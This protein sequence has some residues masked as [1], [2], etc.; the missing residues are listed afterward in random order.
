MRDSCQHQLTC[1]SST[2]APTLKDIERTLDAVENRYKSALSSSHPSQIHIPLVQ[3]ISRQSA[4]TH[5]TR[6]TTP[7]V[8]APSRPEQRAPSPTPEPP[9][10]LRQ[11]NVPSLDAYLTSRTAEDEKGNEE[12]LLPIRPRPA[13]EPS[14]R[15]QLI[16]SGVGMGHAQLHEELEG[17]LADV[18]CQ[19]LSRANTNSRC[20]INSSSTQYTSPTPSKRRRLYWNRLSRLCKVLLPPL[21]NGRIELTLDNLT[22]TKSS[23]A[24]LSVV[25]KKGRGTTCMTLGIV[26]LVLIIF[27]W[28]YMLIKFT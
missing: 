8:P 9:A 12:G 6:P 4:F 27:I 25:S 11:R 26:I 10:V 21:Y 18:S 16:G 3:T 17:Q 20:R 24:N 7:I 23:K 5:S 15:D 13:K 19:F 2:T 22:N 14:Q 1:R 28:T